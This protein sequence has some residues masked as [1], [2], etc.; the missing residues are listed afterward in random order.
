MRENKR[1]LITGVTGFTGMHLARKLVEC[2]YEVHGIVRTDSVVDKL[3]TFV[4]EKI[5]LHVYDEA[6][7]N[8][9]RI[10]HDVHPE[11]V[12][13][14]AACVLT[15]HQYVDL[16]KM[17][18]SNILFGV[19]L[20][21]AM[22]ENDVKYLINTST[23][24]LH[25]DNEDY[26]PVCLYAATKKAFTDL[27]V[28]YQ[29]ACGLKTITLELFD[30]YGNGDWRKKIFNLLKESAMKKKSLPTT[31]GEQKM[32]IV[33]IDDLV[34]AFIIA[35]ERLLQT[36]ESGTYMISSGHA[37]SL[38]DVVRVF[39]GCLGYE[40]DIVWG[41]LPYRFREVM[42]PW[43]KGDTLPGWQPRISLQSGIRRFLSDNKEL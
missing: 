1:V 5:I 18:S 24:W 25:Y 19:K 37:V 20:V 28:Y 34:Q 36:Q 39:S 21:E 22:I 16:D 8:M 33:H 30:S 27:L 14:L 10:V 9:L 13:H 41:K 35:G 32:D 42:I 31:N 23:S 29:E 38:R 17:V 15:K 26:N 11:I 43:S 3:L 2:G 7:D 4:D 40:L 6:N 12:Y